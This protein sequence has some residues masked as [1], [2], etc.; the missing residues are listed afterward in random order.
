M[1]LAVKE[2]APQ[3]NYLLLLTFENEERRQFDLKPYLNLGLFKKLKNIN[4]FKSVRV[5]F[6]TIEWQNG[7]DLDP[8]VLYKESIPC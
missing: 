7:I 5:C 8:E 4:V 6:D 2:V 3:D 1:Y